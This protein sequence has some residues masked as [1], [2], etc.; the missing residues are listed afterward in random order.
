VV[1]KTEASPTAK[2]PASSAR[3]TLIR[4]AL[5]ILLGFAL[6]WT[7]REPRVPEPPATVRASAPAAPPSPAPALPAMASSPVPSPAHSA[8]QQVANDGIPFRGP[9]AIDDSGAEL[10]HPHPIT[11]AHE[12]IYKENN[13]I[14]AM[15]AAMDLGNIAELRRLNR[16]Y[17]E[18]YPED[19]HL[20]QDGYDI[21]ADCMER[22]TEANRISAQR[23]YDSQIA[24]MLRRYVRIHCLQ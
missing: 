18:Q 22:R 6:W 2:I 16:E 13:M 11:P 23:F 3:P 1:R 7:F 14:G 19:S 12:R 24:S 10:L 17:R 15:N 21:I 9:G 5:V 4:G 20:M 8:A